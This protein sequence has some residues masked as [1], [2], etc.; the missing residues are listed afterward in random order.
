MKAR[1]TL[2]AGLALYW[3]LLTAQRVAIQSYASTETMARVLA[4]V[5]FG[6]IAVIALLLATLFRNRVSHI[7]AY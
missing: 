1:L 6:V 3:P 7:L 5:Y 4:I 2:I